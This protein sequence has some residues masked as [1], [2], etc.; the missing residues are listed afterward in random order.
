VGGGAPSSKQGK[1]GWEREFA[2]GKSGKRIIF[3]M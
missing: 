1:G 2:E 3:E